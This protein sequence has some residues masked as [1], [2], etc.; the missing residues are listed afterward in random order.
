MK[1]RFNKL[2]AM[3]IK[4]LQYAVRQLLSEN[5]AI[6]DEISSNIKNGSSCNIHLALLLN[7]NR[8]KYNELS[9]CIK[10]LKLE[11]KNNQEKNKRMFWNQIKY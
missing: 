6:K 7:C 11:I 1:N 9:E 8:K 4:Y 3:E 10:I 2:R 5:K